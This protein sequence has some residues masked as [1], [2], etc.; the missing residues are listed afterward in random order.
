MMP[1][2]RL[3]SLKTCLDGESATVY[4]P[5]LTRYRLHGL[6]IRLVQHL[7]SLPGGISAPMDPV[8]EVLIED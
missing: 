4:R 3:H 6:T 5:I 7:A 2:H 8:A 1:L